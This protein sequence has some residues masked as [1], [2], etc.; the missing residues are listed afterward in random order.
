MNVNNFEAVVIRKNPFIAL[1][2]RLARP[3]FVRYYSK[4]FNS[5]VLRNIMGKHFVLLPQVFHPG[6]WLTSE[7]FVS[8]LNKETVKETDRVLDMGTGSGIAAIIAANL[9]KHVVATD[10]NPNAVKSARINAIL[11]NLDDRIEVRQGDLFEPVQGEKFDVILHNPPFYPGKPNNW[12]EYAFK[13]GDNNET[14]FRFIRDAGKHLNPDGRIL[15]ILTTDTALNAI[16]NEF[17]NNKFNV[18]LVASKHIVGEVMY[19]YEM[20]L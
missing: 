20:R 7:F 4:Q 13:A 6:P 3:L 2:R 16:L 14:V 5:V 19:V 17:K 15:I 1:M 18:N 9:C 8:C 11:N 12:L 10:I